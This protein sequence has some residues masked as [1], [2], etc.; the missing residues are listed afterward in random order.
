MTPVGVSDPSLRDVPKN[1][2]RGS[3]QAAHRSRAP[4]GERRKGLHLLPEG[5]CVAS[6]G[7]LLGRAS[8]YGCHKPLSQWLWLGS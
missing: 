2:K 4:W 6:A 8:G 1:N 7:T 5:I 3:I